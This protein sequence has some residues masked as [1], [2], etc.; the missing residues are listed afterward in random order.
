MVRSATYGGPVNC[1]PCASSNRCRT[2]SEVLPL[3]RTVVSVGYMLCVAS[4]TYAVCLF[5][6]LRLC[7]TPMDAD[8]SNRYG[9]G[10]CMLAAFTQGIVDNA[11]AL[12]AKD[13]HVPSGYTQ[14]LACAQDP[15]NA[16]V[17]N[18]S[19]R[20][21]RLHE[22]MQPG[23]AGGCLP[24]GHASD[25]MC[26]RVYA[27]AITHM[28]GVEVVGAQESGDGVLVYSST[29]N[30][31]LSEPESLRR[32]GLRG[33]AQTVWLFLE[34]DN[35]KHLKGG[36]IGRVPT[37][38]CGCNVCSTNASSASWSCGS[39][40][41]FIGGT[42]GLPTV[43]SGQGTQRAAPGEERAVIDT[44]LNLGQVV[45][46]HEGC[47]AVLT[48]KVK[49]PFRFIDASGGNCL[50]GAITQAALDV[51]RVA[52]KSKE[53]LADAPKGLVDGL[54]MCGSPKENETDAGFLN[55]ITRQRGSMEGGEWCMQTVRRELVGKMRHILDPRARAT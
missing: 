52:R 51:A 42:D 21:P 28:F 31:C 41:H 20:R 23:E 12:K 36:S 11:T 39:G 25:N 18:A 13:L 49:D 45:V 1:A 17:L 16:G 29:A 33:D 6:R 46:N 34:N 9:P 15:E 26:L 22:F 27:P 40:R 32:S 5:W 7:G 30:R 53:D 19:R 4:C 35:F 44:L 37:F 8:G 50:L 24:P 14:W 47:K 43:R 2:T 48:G 54:R 3:C 10:D 55:R 38:Q